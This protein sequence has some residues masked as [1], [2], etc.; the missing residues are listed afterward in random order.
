[1]TAPSPEEESIIQALR[2]NMSLLNELAARYEVSRQPDR[3]EPVCDIASAADVYH[4]LRPEMRDLAQEQ[5]RVV[6]LD[7]RNRVTAQR[8]I[9][10][11][12]VNSSVIRVAEVLR[13]AVVEAVPR[14]ILAHNHPSADPTPSPEDVS[15]T[16]QII[17][18]ADLL[19]ITVLDHVVIARNGYVSMV[20]QELIE[21]P[22]KKRR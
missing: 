17:E 7:I 19:D 13:P 15:I 22:G 8:V 14:I 5:L 12:N 20:A 11:G 16:K 9:Y 2:Q 4:L 1:M 3:E 18:A 6:L 21:D 10:Q